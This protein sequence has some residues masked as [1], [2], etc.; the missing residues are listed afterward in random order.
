LAT[1]KRRWRFSL[2]TLS[3]RRPIRD[4]HLSASKK[5][6]PCRI[7][8]L[9]I[10]FGTTPIPRFVSLSSAGKADIQHILCVLFL[11]RIFVSG[12]FSVEATASSIFWLDC[13]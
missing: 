10:G 2:R 11:F 13:S 4:L 1:K 12:L 7:K 6:P 5:P 8:S 3:S 9:V